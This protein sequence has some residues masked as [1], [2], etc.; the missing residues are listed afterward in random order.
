MSPQAYLQ[1]GLILA[2]FVAFIIAIGCSISRSERIEPE[3]PL[4]YYVHAQDEISG[5]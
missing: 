3:R 5:E 4:W 2:V 1:L